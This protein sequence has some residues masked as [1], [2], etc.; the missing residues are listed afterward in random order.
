MKLNSLRKLAPFLGVIVLCLSLAPAAQASC[1]SCSG[2][3]S[4]EC[5]RILINNEIHIF[6]GV[7]SPC[8]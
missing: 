7:A 3:E 8:Q 4:K 2:D 6:H 5:Y 1:T